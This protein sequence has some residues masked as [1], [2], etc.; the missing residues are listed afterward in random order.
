MSDLQ[1]PATVWLIPREL[2]ATASPLARIDRLAG[3]FVAPALAAD[4]S[5]LGA[6]HDCP[7]AD[8]PG[9]VD[10][11]SLGR[12]LEQLSDIYRGETIAVVATGA[13]IRDLVGREA[14]API[15]LAIDSEGWRVTV[16]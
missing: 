4:S 12:E 13:L 6:A 2:F 8:L 5:W 1:C 9:A 16:S 11:A 15:A 14:R 3:L 10:A 7:V